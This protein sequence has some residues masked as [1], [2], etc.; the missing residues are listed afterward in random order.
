MLSSETYYYV[1]E[2]L[3]GGKLSQRAIAQQAGVHRNTVGT[4]ARGD[5]PDYDAM[6]RVRRRREVPPPDGPERRC[7][8]CGVLVSMP[9]VACRVR[10]EL[11]R[12][13]PP[14][15]RFESPC[16]DSALDL[17][18]R[19]HHQARYEEVRARR[20]AEDA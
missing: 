15:D 20:M 19:P 13:P 7:P 10:E 12:M 4:I 14:C 5:R 16:D 1:Q 11:R 9:C 8:T 2:L 18:L 17:A 6:R 3:A